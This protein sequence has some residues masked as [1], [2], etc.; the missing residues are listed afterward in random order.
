PAQ[1]S[2]KATSTTETRSSETTRAATESP[3]HS[4]ASSRDWHAARDGSSTGHKR[5]AR[6]THRASRR[7]GIVSVKEEH[8][9]SQQNEHPSLGRWSGPDVFSARRGRGIRGDGG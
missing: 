7:R 4:A 5:F 3:K 1:R 8:D 6:P 2:A 9:E